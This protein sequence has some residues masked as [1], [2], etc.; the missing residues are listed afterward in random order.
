MRVERFL[1]RRENKKGRREKK[2]DLAPMQNIYFLLLGVGSPATDH[3]WLS[4]ERPAPWAADLWEDT[5]E[6]RDMS[7]A[8]TEK[9]CFPLSVSASNL[10]ASDTLHVK[11]DHS[12]R[13]C[14]LCMQFAMLLYGKIFSLCNCSNQL[15]DSAS[16]PKNV[17]QPRNMS[18]RSNAN[19]RWD[20]KHWQ[21]PLLKIHIL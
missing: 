18:G 12:T 16:A 8:L 20:A 2:R 15:T 19:L 6:I 14:M 3:Y 21:R 5:E 9:I 4:R 7:A 11:K 1:K 13:L 10:W 17:L